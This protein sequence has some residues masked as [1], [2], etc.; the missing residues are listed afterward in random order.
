[1]AMLEFAVPENPVAHALW[2]L[3]VG[4]CLP[5]LGRLVSPGWAEVGGFLR[6]SI[7]ELWSSLPLDRQLDLWHEAGMRDVRFRRL[8]LGG[9]IVFWGTK[10]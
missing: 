5:G 10:A 7:E 3:Y 6:G 8:S 9:G 4:V 1:M 2:K